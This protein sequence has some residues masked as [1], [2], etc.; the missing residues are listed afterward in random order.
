[1]DDDDRPTLRGDAANRLAGEPLDALSQADLAA[2]I[3][4]LEAEIARVRAHAA[5][6]L[7]HRQAAE[8]VFGAK[9]P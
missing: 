7:A 4:L 3:A 2:R 6:A 9:S 8:A 5:R 1:M